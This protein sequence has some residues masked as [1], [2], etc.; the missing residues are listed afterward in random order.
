V[1]FEHRLVL[2]W[3]VK[4]EGVSVNEAGTVGP[5]GR[6]RWFEVDMVAVGWCCSAPEGNVVSSFAGV[7]AAWPSSSCV[8]FGT[9]WF[10]WECL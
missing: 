1:T 6:Q 5:D 10:K 2:P 7:V 9:V 4:G 8:C 3:V